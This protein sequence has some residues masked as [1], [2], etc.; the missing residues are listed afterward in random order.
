[1]TSIICSV[2]GCHN[3]WRKRRAS[4]QQMCFE[5]GKTRAECCGATFNLYPP[6]STDEARR[7][8]LKALNLK[9][10]PKKPYICSFHFVDGRPSAQH[11]YP[12]KWLGYVPPAKKARRML[13][14][15]QETP[16][17]SFASHETDAMTDVMSDEMTDGMSHR[18]ASTQWIMEHHNYAAD[19][20]HC[21]HLHDQATQCPEQH[22]VHTEL[23]RNDRLSLLYTG[24]SLD[25][26][27]ALADE[28]TAGCSISQ[29][30]PK[31]KLLMTLMKLRLNLLQDDLAERFRVSQSVVSR[32][33]SQWLDLM[34][35][36]MRCCVPWLPRETI[37]A[38]MPQC[39][40]EHYPSTTCI[41]DCSETPL[42]KAHNLDSR[43]ESYSHYYGQNTIKFLIA[44]APCGLIMFISPAYGG[45]CSDKFITA[46]SGFLEYL[47]PGD[48]V[49]ADRGFVIQDLLFER[50]V[51]LVL[52]AFTRR[53]LPLSEED[54]TNTRRIANVRVHVER[55]IRRLKN[56]R[57]VSQTVP[58]N[59]APK[60]DK[61]LRVCAGL[62]NLR[63]DI[64]QEDEE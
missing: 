21:P 42:Q 17:T 9:K 36:K 12:E 30:H 2:R 26:F 56:Y 44:I 55:V 4:L 51:K 61:I 64:I 20:L 13:V 53:G 37:Q 39:F 46:N 27:Q 29:L 40:K 57:I 45:R 22:Q 15:L 49:M 5:H 33:I 38:T 62:C 60:F 11:P 34:E 1:M 43:G 18:D 54:T 16:S 31:D 24:L 32:V 23:L 50:K 52:P 41:I 47:R 25:A 59:L 10:P 19:P 63:G 3:N 58:I 6:P 7:M 35:E 28:L 48:E 14:R 8:W